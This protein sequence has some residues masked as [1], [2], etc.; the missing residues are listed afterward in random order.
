M[1]GA[2]LTTRVLKNEVFVPARPRRRGAATATRCPAAT[3]RRRRR[4]RRRCCSSCR[5]GCGRGRRCSAPGYTTATG[6]STLIGQW[7]RP[8]DVV[9]AVLVVLAWTAIACALV[10]LTPAASRRRPDGARGCAVA[11]ARPRPDARDHAARR[12]GPRHHRDGRRRAAR[13]SRCRTRGTTVGGPVGARGAGHG[14][15]RRGR[16]RPLMA[17]CLAF[18]IM[19]VLRQAAALVRLG[20]RNVWR[21]LRSY[22]Q[23]AGCRRPTGFPEA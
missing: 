15:P 13:R 17:S 19:L 21:D 9:A 23:V 20:S 11:S 2:N 14:L 3:R 22:R 18:A 5:R 6:I 7:H 8:S 1:I 16:R 12:V 4:C 10:A